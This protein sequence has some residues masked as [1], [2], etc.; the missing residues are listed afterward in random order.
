MASGRERLAEAYQNIKNIT[1]LEFDEND[2]DQ[3]ANAVGQIYI[4]G[5][6]FWRGSKKWGRISSVADVR[7]IEL[8]NELNR[9]QRENNNSFISLMKPDDPYAVPHI[10]RMNTREKRKA[11]EKYEK[12]FRKNHRKRIEQLSGELSNYMAPENFVNS[13]LFFREEL[14]EEGGG[15]KQK[16]S[17][18]NE[19][20]ARHS[21]AVNMGNAIL[22][23][24]GYTMEDLMGD[25]EEIQEARKMVGQELEELMYGE[26]SPEEKEEQFRSLLD[27]SIAGLETLTMKRVDYSDDSTL[28][29]AKYNMLV[30]SMVNNI[31][32]IIAKSTVKSPWLEER[33]KRVD[34]LKNFTDAITMLDVR[35]IRKVNDIADMANNMIRQTLIDRSGT[36]YDAYRTTPLKMAQN[37]CM[38]AHLI[39]NALDDAAGLDDEQVGED[40]RSAY[41]IF[42]KTGNSEPYKKLL[43]NYVD[44]NETIFREAEENIKIAASGKPVLPQNQEKIE[45]WFTGVDGVDSRDV[46]KAINKAFTASKSGQL[47]RSNTQATLIL[48]YGVMEAEKKGQKL[49]L[50]DFFE[51]EE[52]QRETGKNAYKFLTEHPIPAENQEKTEENVREYSKIIAALNRKIQDTEMPQVDYRDP[53]KYAQEKKYL[54]WLQQT[55]VDSHQL[56]VVVPDALQSIFIEEQGGAEAYKNVQDQI[57]LAEGMLLATER[58]QQGH[59]ASK[60]SF[61]MLLE[62]D[63]L[64]RNCQASYLLK[65]EGDKYLGKKIGEYPTENAG[66]E[67]FIIMHSSLQD[68]KH[69]LEETS[70]T[71]EG[72]K[73]LV[74][75][76]DSFGAIDSAG[77]D[78]KISDIKEKIMQ[79]E[80]M[81]QEMI[82]QAEEAAKAE[83]EAKAKQPKAEPE[84]PKAEA[85]KAEHKQPEAEKA[86]VEEVKE[87]ETKEDEISDEQEP[88]IEE[89]ELKNIDAGEQKA[90]A[91]PWMDDEYDIDRMAYRDRLQDLYDQIDS[92]DPRFL[93][94]SSEYK[95]VKAGLKEA[96]KQM[97]ELFELG[98]RGDE[99]KIQE[100]NEK[101]EKAMS[102]VYQNSETYLKKKKDAPIGKHYGQERLDAIR[103]VRETL[104]KQGPTL[105]GERAANMFR[106]GA[107]FAGETP[108]Q[109]Q[110]SQENGMIRLGIYMQKAK[111]TGNKADMRL[112]DRVI[113][114]RGKNSKR[115]LQ[116][117]TKLATLDSQL[118]KEE[119]ITERAEA[120]KKAKE[121]LCRR[122]STKKGMSQ[123]MI[124][125]CGILEGFQNLAKESDLGQV[126]EIA[127]D[128]EIQKIVTVGQIGK[129]ARQIRRETE[130]RKGSRYFPQE[131]IGILVA[132]DTFAQLMERK[133]E[134][135]KTI[136]NG[137][138]KD[139]KNVDAVVDHFKNT[140]VADSFA[141]TLTN[142]DLEKKKKLVCTED[143]QKIIG[144][145]GKKEVVESMMKKNQKQN[146]PAQHTV[147]KQ[148]TL[149]L[150]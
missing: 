125:W 7:I 13:R 102:K 85:P 94:S 111:E 124:S 4:N 46:T 81:R 109:K 137:F 144:E 121:L 36:D 32:Q 98:S 19:L 67:S 88:E 147:Q 135:D 10:I 25:G 29:N 136:F 41:K 40:Y 65:T 21:D 26:G 2:R 61:K 105:S 38:I 47:D 148:K 44:N 27:E 142:V 5:H 30:G 82:R 74:E 11:A 84:Q 146:A 77:M 1:G 76:M 63:I 48:A 31:S 106:V 129:Q 108:G 127:K 86:K 9:A 115:L 126:K 119:Q 120:M 104:Y 8:S 128:P 114:E 3:V 66:Q 133:S 96:V 14:L 107:G 59:P 23:G 62:S 90:A 134:E 53:A 49:S 143:M 39:E 70:K 58:V 122:I 116:L 43:S 52:L 72:R 54:D 95:A 34:T 60:K 64:I 118:P 145:Q 149:N 16:T 15:F 138:M 89:E 35:R 130:T 56:Q 51:N 18:N 100:A 80:A 22:L 78:A 69:V 83:E 24:R 75:Y 141:T 17:Y 6:N 91:Y 68:L 117:R 99:K 57:S 55:L 87:K 150:Q 97:D 73:Q 101:F 132:N 110:L 71:K 103:N 131:D 37:N 112:L 123:E 92:H 33:S 20:S 12:D 113:S 79:Q 50:R 42:S 93:H 140:N 45:A 139:K 28:E